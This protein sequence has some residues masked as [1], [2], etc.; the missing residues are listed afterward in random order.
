[1]QG[2]LRQIFLPMHSTLTPL[3]SSNQLLWYFQSHDEQPRDFLKAEEMSLPSTNFWQADKDGC[4]GAATGKRWLGRV[5]AG[6]L[7]HQQMCHWSLVLGWACF[8]GPGLPH[9]V[10]SPKA[11]RSERTEPLSFY[12]PCSLCTEIPQGNKRLQ[13]YLCMQLLDWYRS[14]RRLSKRDKHLSP[15]VAERN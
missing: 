3:L 15:Q 6:T 10:S 8:Q 5:G 13:K 12:L 4:C 9:I 11:S 2:W 7:S 14:Y 1:M